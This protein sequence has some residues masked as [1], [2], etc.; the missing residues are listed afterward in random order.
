MNGTWV[1]AS[2]LPITSRCAFARLGAFVPEMMRHKADRPTGYG[3]SPSNWIGRRR[4]AAAFNLSGGYQKRYRPMVSDLVIRPPVPEP[5]A[6]PLRMRGFLQ[7]VRTN[8][9][10]IWP[11]AAYRDPIV[12]RRFFGRLN[13]LMN[14]PEGIHHV[15]LANAANYRRSRASVRILRPLTGS[16]LLL[17]EGDA[18]KM[19]RRTI[20]PA[21]APRVMPMLAG[22]VVRALEDFIPRLMVRSG[23]TVNLLPEVQRLA[24]DIAGRSMFSLEMD[25]Y[26][27]AVRELLSA[28][29][30]HHSRPGLL[31][32]LLPPSVPTWGDLSRWRFHRRWVKLIDSILADRLRKPT[33]GS[34]K[35]ILDL[36]RD[37]RDPETGEGF[38]REH[39]RDQVATLLLAGHET[40]A[41][42]LFWALYLLCQSP[43][44]VTKIVEEA[45]KLPLNEDTAN[46]DLQALVHTRA[47]IHETLRLFPPAFTLVRE[48]IETD[49]IGSL[50]IPA[51]SI[52]MIAPWV[53]HRHE[54]FW[55]EPDRFLPSRF[56]PGAAAPPRFAFLP[57]GA[58]PRVCVG[59]Q[60]ALME[61]TLVLA[62]LLRTFTFDRR[63]PDAP[64]PVGIV[65]TQPDRPLYLTIGLRQS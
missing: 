43:D 18:W 65:T 15:L 19:Q 21:L 42:T 47:V 44:D 52:V 46:G 57:F 35:D 48:A 24:L 8:A 16:G 9:L 63:S 32:M 59:G 40:T 25:R 30:V 33:N 17:S 38:S 36:L 51:R 27:D 37:A 14:D 54:M 12:S 56:L 10:T 64:L 34:S 50:Q 61:A 55:R 29:S 26:G 49:R 41:V 1:A 45:G 2:S 53:L 7:A 58:G 62:G 6:Q 31:D 3:Q 20:A 39:L 5:P 22:H 11:R 60:F 28:F 23:Q 13:I 4:R